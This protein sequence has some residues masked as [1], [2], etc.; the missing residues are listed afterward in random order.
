MR[1]VLAL[2]AIVFSAAAFAQDKPPPAVAGKPLVQVKP[3]S[4]GAPEK[5]GLKPEQAIPLLR[6][7]L[8]I[9]R[10]ANLPG[11]ADATPSA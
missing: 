6:D 2:V 9:E 1:M 8:E 10:Y 3:K 5:P 11:F 4:G 7:V